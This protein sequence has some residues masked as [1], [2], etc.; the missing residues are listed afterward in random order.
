MGHDKRNS[1]TIQI[2]ITAVNKV[3]SL[4]NKEMHSK[5]NFEV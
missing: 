1:K 2:T 3:H 5:C 4:L